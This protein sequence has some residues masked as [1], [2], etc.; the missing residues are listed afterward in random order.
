M[1]FADNARLLQLHRRTHHDSQQ[2]KEEHLYD[3]AFQV[4]LLQQHGMHVWQASIVHLNPSYV[5]QIELDIQ[6]LFT[7]VDLTLK[8]DQISDI[9]TQEMQDARQYLLN[10]TDPTGH[11]SCIYKARSQ[12]YTTFEYSNPGVPSYKSCDTQASGR[13]RKSICRKFRRACGQLSIRG[14]GRFLANT[15]TIL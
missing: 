3:L 5:R 14:R 11:C 7:T 6:Q 8:I 15:T 2:V 4:I 1:V 10:E 13:L 9:V 12:H